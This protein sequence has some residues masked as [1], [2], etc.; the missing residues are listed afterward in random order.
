MKKLTS[1]RFNSAS[2]IWHVTIIALALASSAHKAGASQADVTSIT[3]TSHKPATTPFISTVNLNISN[4]SV[5]A[6]IQFI[7]T[8]KPGSVARPLSATYSASYLTARGYLNSQTGQVRLPIFGLYA[9]Y[10]NSIVITYSF[11]DGSSRQHSI[12]I[13]TTD[14]TDPCGFTSPIVLQPRTQNADLSYD[15]ILIKSECSANSPTII[16]TDGAIRWVGTIGGSNKGRA[17]CTFFDNAVYVDDIDSAALYRNEL[18]GTV[19][20]IATDYK[21][22]GVVNY[23]HNID[24]GKHGIILD[25]GNK[26]YSESMNVEVDGNGNVLRVWDLA[27]IIS[28]S[29]RA[30]GDNPSQFVF[31]SP[32][33][34]FHNNSAAYRASDNSLIV[35][36]RENFVICLDYNTTAIKWILG[37]PTKKWYQFPSLRRYA[38]KVT[39]GGVPPI[40]Q[41]AVSITSDD[42][43]LLFDNGLN[44][45]FQIPAGISRNY[46]TPRK[47]RLD[48]KA[49]LATEVWNYPRNQSIDAP[50]CGS[51]YEDDPLNYLI[52][53]AYRRLGG[54]TVAEILGLNATRQTAFDYAYPSPDMCTTAFNAIP[55]HLENVVFF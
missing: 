13:T 14:Y 32:A 55:V 42:N 28:A 6:S 2:V 35:S 9:N 1:L 27:A 17:K 21:K 22:V 54:Q 31:P 19:R 52:D 20:I 53:Y 48:L 25:V 33:D 5:L 47:Y 50:V 16:D 40:G 39:P 43:L 45:D 18:D 46:S 26:S 4:L 29:M 11:N 7:I 36:S 23:H 41:H 38:L 30:G 10:S 49:G 8:P 37:D 44:S 15:Y 51:V 34:W 24:H 3:I 12:V